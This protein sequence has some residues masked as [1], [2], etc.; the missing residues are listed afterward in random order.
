MLNHII[1]VDNRDHRFGLHPKH[2][3]DKT[4]RI[5]LAGTLQSRIH[6][7]PLAPDLLFSHRS[8]LVVFHVVAVV[9]QQ[10]TAQET[11]FRC[12]GL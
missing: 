8:R 2:T 4:L 12:H 7:L 10:S 6:L 9:V 11:G 1:P 3:I 5:N